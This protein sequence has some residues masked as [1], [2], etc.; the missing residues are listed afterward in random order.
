MCCRKSIRDLV[1]VVEV[2]TPKPVVRS[3]WD[4][5]LPH[6][7]GLVNLRDRNCVDEAIL[8]LEPFQSK[9]SFGKVYRSKSG[10]IYGRNLKVE[11][12]PIKS[13]L[14]SLRD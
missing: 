8:S 12:P 14:D 1:K 4:T 9:G 6:I 3:T 10:A 11:A 13:R 5:F 2:R 7:I